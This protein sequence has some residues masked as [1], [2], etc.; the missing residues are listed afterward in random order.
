MSQEFNPAKVFDGRRSVVKDGRRLLVL[1]TDLF[2]TDDPA[3]KTAEIQSHLDTHDPQYKNSEDIH[4]RIAWNYYVT[5]YEWLAAQINLAIDYNENLNRFDMMV[6]MLIDSGLD[7]TPLKTILLAETSSENNLIKDNV[8][9]LACNMLLEE[10]AD[11]E[12]TPKIKAF[13]VTPHKLSKTTQNALKRLTGAPYADP[14]N[15]Q[16]TKWRD[17]IRKRVKFR[18]ITNY[19]GADFFVTLSKI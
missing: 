16:I 11:F 15:A 9:A 3:P 6:Q 2:K 8:A 17:L 18:T 4:E 12:R 1:L 10:I 13:Q 5:L 19:K 14:N 7:D